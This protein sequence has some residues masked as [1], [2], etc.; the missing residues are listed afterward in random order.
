MHHGLRHGGIAAVGGIRALRLVVRCE[1]V[2]NEGIRGV[3]QVRRTQRYL[4]AGS[5]KDGQY[6]LYS[7][8]HNLLG[9]H[10]WI[11][12]HQ[13]HLMHEAGQCSER[14]GGRGVEIAVY[15]MSPA[16]QEAD[17]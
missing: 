5:V 16:L 12:G 8:H 13:K 10:Q 15:G 1:A 3:L 6:P 9:H 14:H 11:D 4:E 17:G 7:A 2:A